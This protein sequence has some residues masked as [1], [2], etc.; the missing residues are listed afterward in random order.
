[1]W[2]NE[3]EN[4]L[5]RDLQSVASDLRW[6]AVELLRLADQLKLSGNDVDAQAVLRL[7]DLF[8]GDEQR[9]AG[10]A[11]EVKAKAISRNKAH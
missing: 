8:Q 6:S 9:L 10:Y 4:E 2:L 7:C 11:E 5:R 3:S 1:M